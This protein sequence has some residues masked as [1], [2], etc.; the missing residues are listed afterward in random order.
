[1]PRKR[2]SRIYTRRRGG[3]LRFYVDLRDY[4]VV[5]MLALTDDRARDLT[6]FTPIQVPGGLP[7][8]R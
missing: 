6:R 1:M 8:D 5:F 7:I 2:D 3:W 4:G